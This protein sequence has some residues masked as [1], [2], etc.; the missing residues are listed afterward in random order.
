M[1]FHPLVEGKKL[2]EVYHFGYSGTHFQVFLNPIYWF[3]FVGLTEKGTYYAEHQGKDYVPP[4][5]NGGSFGQHGMANASDT[6][7]GFICIRVP[8]YIENPDDE[9]QVVTMRT[10]G[11][12]LQSILFLVNHLLHDVD[13]QEEEVVLQTAQQLF[14]V[15]TYVANKP[16]QPHGAGL[17]LSL[18]YLSRKYLKDKGDN[19]FIAGAVEQMEKHYHLQSKKIYKLHRGAIDVHIRTNGV[20]HMHTNGNCACLGA[21]PR[22]FG[23][24][25]CYLSSHN[26]DTVFQQFNLLVG[27]AYIWQMVR[28]GLNNQTL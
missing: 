16:G 9:N 4:I 26:V 21:M 2:P 7:N 14:V 15:G 6:D 28:E 13:K 17:D 20:L 23:E 19:I 1:E 5:V 8:A 22:N 3:K 25:G 27:I 24:M 18:S 12:T 11:M 10:L